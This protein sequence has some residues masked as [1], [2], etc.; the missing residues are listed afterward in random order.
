MIGMCYRDK[1]VRE[2]RFGR[3]IQILHGQRHERDID[4]A[5]H[6]P[7]D[8]LMARA[9]MHRDIDIRPFSF[10]ASELSMGA[11]SSRMSRSGAHTQTPEFPA[12]DLSHLA[13]SAVMLVQDP[14]RA[15]EQCL[16]GLG[17]DHAARCT[18]KKLN[19]ELVLKLADLHRDRRLRDIQTT[20]TCRKRLCL[21]DHSEGLKLS[22]LHTSRSIVGTFVFFCSGCTFGRTEL[23]IQQVYRKIETDLYLL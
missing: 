13:N 21:G 8:K 11:G 22:D 3:D 4:L 19:A 5:I 16:A 18:R 14:S 2:E 1:L 23:N 6:Y 15:F 17:D 7:I 9:G 20:R 12:R 10:G